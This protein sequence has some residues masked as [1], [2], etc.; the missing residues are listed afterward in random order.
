M[1]PLAPVPALDGPH[2]RDERRDNAEK[3]NWAR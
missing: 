1:S 3:Y 2:L